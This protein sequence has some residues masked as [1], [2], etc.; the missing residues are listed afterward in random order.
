[1]ADE[2][3]PH[4]AHGT[5]PG[6]SALC[7]CQVI[8]GGHLVRSPSC[9][10]HTPPLV[11]PGPLREA[12]Q[13]LE[14]MLL[15]IMEIR[16]ACGFMWMRM[17]VAADAQDAFDVGKREFETHRA[18]FQRLEVSLPVA[19][20]QLRAALHGAEAGPREGIAEI[21]R[22]ERIVTRCIR[23]HHGFAHGDYVGFC[24]AC[25]AELVKAGP[26]ATREEHPCATC[27]GRGWIMRSE[28][29]DHGNGMGSG[30]AWNEP[31]PD[32]AATRSVRFL[33]P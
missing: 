14:Q 18:A 32:C 29:H 15:D 12:Q 5:E 10:V 21:Q 4:G 20:R 30:G 31:C 19:I 28:S 24:L 2:T 9:P 6:A 7:T 3:T 22:V 13:D 11:T 17:A 23:E 16:S 25:A 1:M 27:N 8:T 33:T 26:Q